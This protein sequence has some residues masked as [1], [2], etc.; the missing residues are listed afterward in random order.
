VSCCGL[1]RRK[2]TWVLTWRARALVLL[3]LIAAL[4]AFSRLIYP[5][6]ATT[7]PTYG[8][9]L[10]VEGR[11]PYTVFEQAAA[12]FNKHQYQVLV[13][14]G[15]PREETLCFPEY[16]SYAE[17]AAALLKR[18]GV[19]PNRIVAIPRE[20]VRRDR[21]YASAVAVRDWLRQ[22]GLPIKSLD[23][24]SLGAHARR[25]QWLFR[26]AIGEG[27]KVGVIAAT[28]ADYDAD[29]WWRWSGGVHAVIDE[30]VSYLYARYF[31][32]P[33]NATQ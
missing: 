26:K 12:F 21:T 30:T 3:V 4:F 2:E 11:L 18:L 27:V 29:S 33:R 14:T 1:L 9:V 23:V 24:F 20:S 8:E 22:S 31:F 16:P 15:G 17:Y 19:K 25:T 10:V 7:A 6:L 5:F 32:V 28:P 13:T